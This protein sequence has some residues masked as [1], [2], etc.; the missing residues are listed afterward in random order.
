MITQK[1]D[2]K[3]ISFEN[4]NTGYSFE[5]SSGKLVNV[6]SK[7][8]GWNMI[9]RP[10]LGKSFEMMI[11]LD[12]R[13]NNNVKGG[14]PSSVNVTDNSVEFVYDTV[15]SQFGGEHPIKVVTKFEIDEEIGTFDCSIDNQSDLIVEDVRYPIVDDFT[16]PADEEKIDQYY[17]GYANLDKQSIYPFIRNDSYWGTDSPTQYLSDTSPNAPFYMLMGEKQGVYIGAAKKSTDLIVW[18]VQLFPGY[19]NAMAPTPAG[20]W[21]PE[22]DEISGKKVHLCVTAAQ[23]PFVMPKTSGQIVPIAI[24]AFAGTWH[25]GADIYK[26]LTKRWNL[27]PIKPPAWISEPHSW[28]QLHINSPEDELR[29]K[30]TEL[31]DVGRECAKHGIKAIQLVGWNDGGQDRGNPSH[32]HDPRLGTFEELKQAIAEIEAMGVKMILF[33]K[34]T[35]SDIS[36]EWYKDE[37]HELTAKNMWGDCYSWPGYKYQT[38]SQMVGLSSR[39]LVTMCMNSEKY[40]KICDNEIKKI[41]DLGASGTLFDESQHHGPGLACFDMSHGHKYGASTYDSDNKLIEGFRKVS[42]AENP[43]FLYAGEACYDLEFEQY[44]LAYIRT[45]VEYVI[46][47][48]RYTFPNVAYMTA[49]VGFNDRNMIN[50]CLMYKYIISYEPYNFKGRPGDYPITLEYGKKM[51]ALRTGLREYFWDGD[52]LDTTVGSVTSDGV[53]HEKWAGYRSDDGKLGVVICNFSKEPI[54]VKPKFDETLTKYRFVDGNDYIPYTEEIEIPPQSAI[55]I[56]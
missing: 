30:Y 36:T 54:K 51:D 56:I 26:N 8:T 34:F 18:K 25:K 16:K 45:K 12:G 19:D 1:N 38:T 4:D 52:F 41:V 46:P 48:R 53:A 31:V 9:K 40:R 5:L 17:F 28:L 22:M 14:T 55:V 3:I 50:Q 39:R 7:L 11:P 2:G 6:Y 20:A 49:I 10:E 47:V 33:S 23:L 15:T 44:D 27:K 43:D 32:S 24:K 42:A 29:Y 35:W 37:L 13:R 21:I